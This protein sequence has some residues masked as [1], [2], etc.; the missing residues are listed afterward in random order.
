MTPK[1]LTTLTRLSASGCGS[2]LTTRVT[3]GDV[4]IPV[5]FAPGTMETTIIITRARECTVVL[6]YNRYR[7]IRS[8][9]TILSRCEWTVPGDC[10]H[11]SCGS[12]TTGSSGRRDIT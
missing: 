2:I 10:F 11:T 1:E 3:G 9:E 8:I 6:N 5:P 4:V 12:S 7:A